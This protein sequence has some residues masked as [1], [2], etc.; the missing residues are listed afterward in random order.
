MGEEVTVVGVAV[1]IVC[2]YCHGKRRFPGGKY[3]KEGEVINCPVCNGTGTER[4][5]ITLREFK[6]LLDNTKAGD[7]EARSTKS[8][9]RGERE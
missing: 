5:T 4:K 7:E 2:G 3:K 9:E 6:T 1:A 8:K